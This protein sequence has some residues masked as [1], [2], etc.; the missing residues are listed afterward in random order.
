MF[1]FLKNGFKKPIEQ[2]SPQ[3]QR[4]TKMPSKVLFIGKTT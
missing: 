2:M 3:E 1:F 4:K